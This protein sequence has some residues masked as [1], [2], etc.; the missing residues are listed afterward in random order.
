[1]T[2]FKMQL[3][4]QFLNSP[5]IG[6]LIVDRNRNNLLVN[7]CLNEMFGYEDGEL[8]KK[9]ASI[10]HISKQAYIDFGIE[11]FN[12]VLAGKPV[13]IDYKFRHKNGTIFWAHISGDLIEE[14]DSVLWT[15]VDITKRK[16]LELKNAQQAKIIE[17]IH[18]CVITSD[19]KGNITSCNEGSEKLL[20]Y[21]SSEIVGKHASYM[22]LK[23][24]YVEFSTSIKKLRKNGEYRAE[25][26][27]LK[28]SKDVAYVDLTLA[29]LK[30]EYLNPIGFIGYAKDITAKKL[31]EKGLA[32]TNYNLKQYMDAIDKIEIGIF[33]VNDDFSIRFMNKTML[34]WFGNQEGKTCY[35][36][37]AGLS[38]PCSYCK[39]EEV[40]YKNHK[41]T[42]EATIG[43][44]QSFEIVATSI[45]NLDGTTSKMEIIRNVT[46]QKK[47]AQALE[48]QAQHDALTGLPNRFLFHDRLEQ[49]IEKADRANTIM[50]LFFIDLDHF[51]E[52][53]DSFGHKTGDE[54]LKIVAQRL[55][56]TIRKKDTLARLG[57]DEFTVI[58]DDLK[59]AQDASKLAQKIIDSLAKPMI[60]NN[61]ELYVSSSIGI[62]FFPDDGNNAQNLLKYADSAMY[63]AKVEGRNNFQ[64]YSSEM[65]E[66]AFERVVMEASL[67][68][69]LKNEEFIVYYQPQIDAKKD[70]LLGMEA[71]VRWNHPTMGI[72]SPAKFIPLAELTGLIVELDRLVMKQAMKQVS[73]WHKEGLNPGR[74]SLN[75]AM[76]QLQKKDFISFLKNMMIET[77]CKSQWLEFEVTEGQI[78]TNP[79]EAIKILNQIS[80][81]GIELAV[82]DFGTGYSSL[83]Y[84]K[85]L[86]IDKLK[87]DQSFIR[88]LPTDE[89][90]AAITKAVIALA[91]SLNL[92]TIAEGVESIEQKD[93]LVNNGCSYIQGYFYSKPVPSN[94]MEVKL[95][96]KMI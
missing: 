40:I 33:V 38:E 34:D 75:L 87:I 21:K 36:S 89:E 1:M 42:Y 86:P 13:G 62:S 69:A 44:G 61:N 84:L 20:G 92:K 65:T 15:I 85:K 16:E 47:I 76:K 10:L 48:H 45:K 64:F 74:L 9:T 52:I 6:I 32:D 71:L 53:N 19:L 83:A 70:K 4:E 73:A 81:L 7:N 24:D 59:L 96:N 77:E 28:K 72:V 30:D 27:L 91:S 25:T 3:M 51:K 93:F 82:D 5:H 35:S 57:G 39:L 67:R 41:V 60:I 31:A 54:V 22:Y 12:L 79:E 43:D 18:D 37:I 14:R 8:I 80:E 68:A 17:E 50:A 49:A 29:T 95:K 2:K 55:E 26:R 90:D 78:M 23:A 46:E 88:D 11:A 63:K 66:L 58:I 56:K 94:E